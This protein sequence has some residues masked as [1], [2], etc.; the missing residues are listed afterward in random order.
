[1]NSVNGLLIIGLM[2]FINEP[3]FLIDFNQSTDLT[4]WFIVDDVVMGGRSDGNFRINEN[5]SGVFYGFVSTE[6]YG[7][8]SSV[9]YSFEERTLKEHTHCLIRLKGDGKAYQFRVKDSAR[10]RYSYISS[11][12]TKE[13]WETIRIELKSMYP[14]FRGMRL[15]EPNYTAESLAEIAILIGNKRNESFRLEID[16]IKFQ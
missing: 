14:S 9:R 15:D 3:E 2:M 7:G 11:F 4:S 12:E 1:M 8:F 10:K 5:G 13:E 6:N 16:W